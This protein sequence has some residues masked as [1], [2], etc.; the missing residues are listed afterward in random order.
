MDKLHVPLPGS[1]HDIL[2][3]YDTLSGI[4]AQLKR[5]RIGESVYII[6]SPKIGGY[7]QK[8][9]VDSLRK[10]GFKDIRVY[11]LP[12]GEK[13]KSLAQWRKVLDDIAGFD[14]SDNKKLF[15]VNLGG[16]VVGDLGGF[17]S[18]TYHRGTPYVQVPT[19]LLACVD[20]GLGGKVGVNNGK[21]KNSVGMFWQPSLIYADLKLLET[22]TKREVK[23]GI[24]E[25]IKYGA[26][27][28]LPLFSLMEK[29]GT[30]LLALDRKLL[31][32]VS[33]TC[34][35][36][37][38]EVVV[39]DECDTNNVRIVLNYGHTVGHAIESASSYA[40]RHGES[41]SVGIACANDIAVKLGI[42]DRTVARRVEALLTSL[43]LPT[44]IKN[45]RLD[46]IMACMAND[47]KF[48]NGRNRF[49]LLEEIGKTVIREGI[50]NGIIKQVVK[51]RL[52]TS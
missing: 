47:K 13:N 48:I 8:P 4:G 29:R 15:I 52:V 5:L 36:M 17:V 41:V 38:L 28:S 25:V 20:C 39:A 49:V 23:S 46:D 24:A 6:T 35:R 11:R 37:K 51:N 27:M 14:K 3:G 43:K 18:G 30:D 7:Y 19:T 45:C 31:H 44:K 32:E 10:S 40:Y 50:D 34:Y 12:D 21:F 2:I 9:V 1:P 26:A 16:G 33:K 42:L 22:L